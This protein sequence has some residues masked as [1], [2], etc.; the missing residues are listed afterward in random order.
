[1]ISV[2]SS[3]LQIFALQKGKWQ[4]ISVRLG[5][6]VP[7]SSRTNSISNLR[8]HTCS[9]HKFPSA[10][11]AL[12]KPCPQ[13]SQAMRDDN[14]STESGPPWLFADGSQRRERGT[15][16]GNGFD[17]FYLSIA[18]Q[19]KRGIW[20]RSF[21]GISTGFWR[22]FHNWNQV[23]H[24]IVEKFSQK[25]QQVSRISLPWRSAHRD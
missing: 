22:E 5:P 19:Y 16:A 17:P 4:N 9:C 1:M 14:L 24:S 3:T 7:I 6:L 12:M 23:K 10:M 21:S 8:L 13:T 25:T 15:S 11:P 2:R 18:P 20:L